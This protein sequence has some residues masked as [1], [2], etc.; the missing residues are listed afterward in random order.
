MVYFSVDVSLYY[1]LYFCVGMAHICVQSMD[2][3]WMFFQGGHLVFERAV[4]DFVLPGPLCYFEK[5]DVIMTAPGTSYSV[6]GYRYN[7]ITESNGSDV[8][9]MQRARITGA[10]DDEDDDDGSLGASGGGATKSDDDPASA[11]DMAGDG[12]GGSEDLLREGASDGKSGKRGKS[13]VEKGAPGR[14]VLK[15]TWERFLGEDVLDVAI[16][17]TTAGRGSDA[18]YDIVALALRSLY[19]LNERGAMSRHIRLTC[20][21]VSLGIF[22]VGGGRRYGIRSGS[23]LDYQDIP[24]VNARKSL[25]G[26]GPRDHVVIGTA[27]GHMIVYRDT[28]VLWQS[29]LPLFGKVQGDEGEQQQVK[30]GENGDG[31]SVDVSSGG[32]PIPAVLDVFYSKNN[33]FHGNV[34]SI[35]FDGGLSLS[36]LGSRMA[37]ADSLGRRVG[38]QGNAHAEDMETELKGVNRQVRRLMRERAE[39]RGAVQSPESGAEKGKKGEEG[40]KKKKKPVH[41]P[42]QVASAVVPTSQVV[43]FLQERLREVQKRSGRHS[44]EERNMNSGGSRQRLVFGDEA[45]EGD[46]GAFFED[47]PDDRDGGQDEEAEGDNGGEASANGENADADKRASKRNS[48]DEGQDSARSNSAPYCWESEDMLTAA[49]D[50]M[51]YG[52]YEHVLIMAFVWQDDVAKA[53]GLQLPDRVSVNLSI[54]FPFTLDTPSC[55]QPAYTSTGEVIGA[56][57]GDAGERITFECTGT[58]DDDAMVPGGGGTAAIMCVG[59]KR[60]AILKDG[61]AGHSLA[62]ANAWASIY[63]GGQATRPFLE[64][65]GSLDS[66][67][68][69]QHV[70]FVPVDGVT[71]GV[72]GYAEALAT[73]ADDASALKDH[74]TAEGDHGGAGA[75]GAGEKQAGSATGEED[76]NEDEDDDA[77]SGDKTGNVNRV[78]GQLSTIPTSNRLS[79]NIMYECG[80]VGRESSATPGVHLHDVALSVQ[81]HMPVPL[82]A[83][84]TPVPV[85]QESARARYGRDEFCPRASRPPVRGLDAAVARYREEEYSIV[86]HDDRIWFVVF[87]VEPG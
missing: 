75:S 80:V 2:G 27:T 85:N 40:R 24:Q 55:A 77:G 71:A 70:A 72:D 25:E 17:R 86:S 54:P 68:L 26:G 30:D 13:S 67:A 21:P 65:L 50:H 41:P 64:T 6:F 34:M 52:R 5:T 53:Q 82:L 63:D 11:G 12:S 87:G 32:V 20:E 60:V 23:V 76:D 81:R 45:D 74:E 51:R 33:R 1:A 47:T 66:I 38:Q 49:L 18:T 35:T 8:A 56:N 29:Q 84:C 10:L 39:T 44:D 46:D 57:D 48:A 16:A 79:M 58:N 42:L 19:F 83:C 3:V 73:L 59:S 22:A 37:L 14:K 15:A 61:H 69:S 4:P 7:T 78:Y 28:S 62:E 36:Y 9:Y 43:A 31:Q